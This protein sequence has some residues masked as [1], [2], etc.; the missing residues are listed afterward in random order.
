[1]TDTVSS[2]SFSRRKT[3]VYALLPA[4]LL[5]GG[6][7]GCARLIEL[8]RPPLTL[9]YGWGFNEDS[10]VFMPA[11]IPRDG[12]ITRPEKVVSFVKQ[13]FRMPKPNDTYRII[14]IGGSNVH[15]M[16]HNLNRMVQ[17]LSGTSGE[18]RRFE[19][20]NCGGFAYGTRRL[21][22]MMPELLTYAP[23]LLLIYSGHNEFEE[24]LHKSL[25]DTRSIPVQK[26]AYSL[27]MLRFVR[28]MVNSAQL[29]FLDAHRLRQTRP[30]EIDA[31][32]GV[33]D[34]S[35]AEIEE[36][37]RGYHENLEDIVRR[38]REQDIP[39]VISTVATNYWAPDLHYR[40]AREKEEIARCYREGRYAEGLQ[41]AR[42]TLRVSKRHQA[43]D[44]ENGIIRAI[45]ATFS[46]PLVEAEQL[47]VD[48]EPNGVPGET[49]LSDRCHLTEQGREIVIYA[50]EEVI[51]ELA[52][53]GTND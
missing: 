40:F 4:L 7:E 38:A 3:V 17:R 27:A 26:A 18:T 25:V 12:M 11:G 21:R 47:I 8:W 49:L 13:R 48:A 45:A 44:V 41:L 32:T 5:F 50:F 14:I 1:M 2:L 52:G 42:E 9:D 15:Y 24:L 19:I 20:I 34:F 37:M 51:R 31:S 39:V 6:I 28:D 30:P 53:S 36:H 43:S 46:L 10:R 16:E 22:I 33:Y 23:D 29:L 35:D